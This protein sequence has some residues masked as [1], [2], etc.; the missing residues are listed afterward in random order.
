MNFDMKFWIE[1]ATLIA[2]IG[3][4][5]GWV[6]T[7]LGFLGEKIDKLETKQKKHNKLIERMGVVEQKAKTTR[8]KVKEIEED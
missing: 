7:S 4:F 2:T 1:L 3:I 5:A 6:K 8:K